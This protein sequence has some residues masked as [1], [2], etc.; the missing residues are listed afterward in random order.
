MLP[1]PPP[2][3]GGVGLWPAHASYRR[4]DPPPPFVHSWARHW[5]IWQC[6][7]IR[8]TSRTALLWAC[9]FSLFV[10][11]ATHPEEHCN[12]TRHA[13]CNRPVKCARQQ[14]NTFKL[15][16]TA[17]TWQNLQTILCPTTCSP[18]VLFASYPLPQPSLPLPGTP[19]TFC[20]DGWP[21]ISYSSWHRTPHRCKTAFLPDIY[22]QKPVQ[23]GFLQWKVG[24]KPSANNRRFCSCFSKGS[25]LI[26]SQF[27]SIYTQVYVWR[28]L[29]T[30]R[31]SLYV[32]ER[33]WTW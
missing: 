26:S 23:S 31:G 11:E 10:F 1:D 32:G 18:P 27:V 24:I 4:V 3:Q 12:R 25:L 22:S 29:A 5:M 9:E 8:L 28:F 20:Q 19:C 17:G 21:C 14:E 33:C 16:E 30:W 13:L 7:G 2:T 6:F 15:L